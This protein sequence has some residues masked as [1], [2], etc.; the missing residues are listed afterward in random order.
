VRETFVNNMGIDEWKI[1]LKRRELPDWDAL[2]ANFWEVMQM[3]ERAK[4]EKNYNI[5]LGPNGKRAKREKSEEEERAPKENG[6]VLFAGSSTGKECFTC[7]RVGH[8]ARDCPYNRGGN[9][10]N[11]RQVNAARQQ[12]GQQQR[13]QHGQQHQQQ[14]GGNPAARPFFSSNNAW[15]GNG[16]RTGGANSGGAT[17]GGTRGG[18]SKGERG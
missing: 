5:Q 17:G 4:R 18:T 13:Q 14:A 10:N 11:N 12:Q 15:S 6:K 2:E 7:H 1:E 3:T 16:A 9:S 8:F